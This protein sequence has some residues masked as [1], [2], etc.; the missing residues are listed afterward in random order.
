MRITNWTFSAVLIFGLLATGTVGADEVLQDC[1]KL[2]G[3]WVCESGGKSLQAGN[4]FGELELKMT[5]TEMDLNGQPPLR[6]PALRFKNPLT[7]AWG[8]LEFLNGFS[9]LLPHN[10]DTL[11]LGIDFDR[12]CRR[13]SSELAVLLSYTQLRMSYQA[14]P[15]EF[16]AEGAPESDRNLFF[17]AVLFGPAF[18]SNPVVDGVLDTDKIQIKSTISIRADHAYVDTSKKIEETILCRRK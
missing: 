6:T 8:A 17:T 4:L 5:V 11:A 1:P 18:M 16:R 9:I 12:S 14:L 10:Y 7:N 13:D 3:S 2:D 15:P